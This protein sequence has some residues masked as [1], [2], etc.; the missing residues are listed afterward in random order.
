MVWRVTRPR[1]FT[2][3][4]FN[5]VHMPLE[6]EGDKGSTIQAPKRDRVR[7]ETSQFRE[8]HGTPATFVH[9]NVSRCVCMPT[10]LCMPE[11]D[12]VQPVIKASILRFVDAARSFVP[13][14][15]GLARLNMLRGL[16]RWTGQ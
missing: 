14:G 3:L 2:V 12:H 16:D 5:Q 10:D 6:V 11:V 9:L 15:H 1:V 4:D 8:V 7:H 13:I